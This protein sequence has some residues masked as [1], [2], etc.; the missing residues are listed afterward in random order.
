MATMTINTAGNPVPLSV[1]PKGSLPELAKETA[2]A[3]PE[4]APQQEPSSE[5]LQQV[6][7]EMKQLVDSKMPNSLSFSLDDSTGKTIV[8]ITDTKTGEMIRQI[9]SEEMMELARSLDK[10]Q[11]MLLRQ[12]V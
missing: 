3:V 11:G 4:K 2:V 6:V 5:Q 9:P 8:R 7:K 1:A 10:M 12:E